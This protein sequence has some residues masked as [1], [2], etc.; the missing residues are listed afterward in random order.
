M[1]L[2]AALRNINRIPKEWLS[3]LP[4]PLLC[5]RS[6]LW[7]MS[8]SLQT[9]WRRGLHS[10][11]SSLT[12]CVDISAAKGWHKSLRRFQSNRAEHSSPRQRSGRMHCSPQVSQNAAKPPG[13]VAR[14]GVGLRFLRKWG[15]LP[16]Q[17]GGPLFLA[18]DTRS[19][20][21]VAALEPPRRSDEGKRTLQ[22][23]LSPVLRTCRALC[24]LSL[25]LAG[26]PKPDFFKKSVF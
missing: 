6:S 19:L 1:F 16:I 24:K 2:F 3:Y 22:C 4:L 21:V 20:L 15:G 11:S 5:C 18:T 10:S 25:H 7:A 8:W 12:R 9:P 13:S 26:D 17:Y 23:V 14:W